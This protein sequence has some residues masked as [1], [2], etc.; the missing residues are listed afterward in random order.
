MSTRFSLMSPTIPNPTPDIE[1]DWLARLTAELGR[2]AVLAGMDEVGRGA[3]AGPVGVGVVT[4]TADCPLPPEGLH[5]SKKLS[6][7]KR[8]GLIDPIIAWGH[9][10]AVGYGS[11]DTINTDGIIAGLREAGHN[12]LAQLDHQ[13][14]LILLDGVHDWYTG[15]LFSAHPTPPVVTIVKGDMTC[16]VISAASVLAKVARDD[17]MASLDED[18]VGYSWSSNKGYASPAHIE[19]LTTLGPSIHHRTSWHLPG[20]ST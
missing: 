6:L 7:A 11:V 19:A 18:C 12:A 2:P 13:P 4:I 3:L 15:D 10:S 5:D 14:D 8:L 1:Q 20:V 9:D 16:T 17:L